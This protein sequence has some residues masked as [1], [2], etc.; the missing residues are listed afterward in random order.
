MDDFILPNR[1]EDTLKAI[2]NSNKKY[3]LYIQI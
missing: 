3:D 2:I 1:F